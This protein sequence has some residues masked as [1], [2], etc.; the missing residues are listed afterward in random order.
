MRRPLCGVER[1]GF[2]KTAREN[3]KRGLWTYFKVKLYKAGTLSRRLSRDSQ[4]CSKSASDPLATGSG[5]LR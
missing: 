5:S 4:T 3:I 1:H 2:P